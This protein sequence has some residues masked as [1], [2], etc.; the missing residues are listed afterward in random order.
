MIA[1]AKRRAKKST[2]HFG[3]YSLQH[4]AYCRAC[5]RFMVVFGRKNSKQVAIP[6]SKRQGQGI[7]IFCGHGHC[8]GSMNMVSLTRIPTPREVLKGLQAY[9]R[10]LKSRPIDPNRPRACAA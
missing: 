6:A 4:R 1:E 10:D 3:A 9:E 7:A 8:L 2:L 5:R